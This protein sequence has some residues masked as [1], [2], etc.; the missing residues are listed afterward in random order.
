MSWGTLAH[1][2]CLRFYLFPKSLLNHYCPL[3][4]ICGRGRTGEVSLEESAKAHSPSDGVVSFVRACLRRLLPVDFLGTDGQ[5]ADRLLDHHVDTFVKLRRQEQLSNK[6]FLNGMRLTKI[7][8]L[9]SAKDGRKISKSDHQAAELLLV[10]ILR[11]LFSQFV[12]P[13]LSSNF[14][15]TESEFSGRQVLYYRKPAWSIFRSLSMR[16][17]LKQQYTEINAPD[18]VSR[19]EQ[20]KMGF[21]RL[22]LLP[23]ESGVRPIATLCKRENLRI[24]V[25]SEEV[26]EEDGEDAD[27][28][29]EALHGPEPRKK[30]KIEAVP[31]ATAPFSASWGDPRS[32]NQ[33]LTDSFTV[34][35]FEHKRKDDKESSLF[36]AGLDGLHYF[37]PKYRDFVARLKRQVN[38]EQTNMP[39]VY[40]GSVDIQ[41]CYDNI[42]QS[43]LLQVVET[44]LQEDDY[45][46]QRYDEVY[47]FSSMA[48][49]YKRQRKRACPPVDFLPLH[50]A[51]GDIAKD[52]HQTIFVDGVKCSLTK[53]NQLIEQLREHL[54]SHLVTVRG[55]YGDRF[56]LQS[57]GI[58]QGSV[59]S[60]MLCNFYYG[61]VERELLPGTFFGGGE[62]HSELNRVVGD[63]E[64]LLVR[65]VDDFML[66]TTN[67]TLLEKFLKTMYRGEP[68]LGV[69]INRQ[70]T[71][72][73]VPVSFE[74]EDNNGTN[75]SLSPPS[76]EVDSGE[77]SVA[78]SRQYFPWCGMLFDVQSGEVRVDYS[79]FFDGKGGDVLTV[80]RA[81]QHGERLAVAMKVFVRPRCI[82]VLFDRLVNSTKT[83]ITNF[84]QL[85]AF[86]AVKTA[87]YMRS[88]DL[89]FSSPKANLAFIVDSIESTISYSYNLINQR[90]KSTE[91]PDLEASFGRGAAFWLGWKAFYD[92]LTLLKARF[93]EFRYLSRSVA[94]KLANATAA[95]TAATSNGGNN[96]KRSRQR[97]QQ[98]RDNA[99]L[100][101]RT[102]AAAFDSMQLQRLLPRDARKPLGLKREG[103]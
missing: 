77:G 12:I 63:D 51:A 97:Q 79:R 67:L 85:L 99:A 70:K 33:I 35:Q 84:Y 34:L 71:Q 74:S 72:V 94:S 86:G 38:G 78:G 56:L 91:R 3:P 66:V 96:N 83:Q 46:I 26:P 59:L 48:R 36:G 16:K 57:T 98:V 37:Y 62:G 102:A 40:F 2:I 95:V 21:S 58:P 11:W 53:K 31:K 69:N 25:P 68:R 28:I 5:N 45:L 101:R 7:R 1:V 29:I 4:E 22:R 41:H 61:N 47:P 87:E 8:W 20:Q 81:S 93:P 50:R 30:R 32:T 54:T 103:G 60:T 90:L 82:P 13:L 88:S 89:V 10:R 17:L 73:S 9:F 19:L 64:L 39:Q 6:F 80:E 15:V 75:I 65:M 100:L 24:R 27:E 49:V 44:I 92:T 76:D 18:A 52:H 23:K 14:H 42:D 43:H 55:R